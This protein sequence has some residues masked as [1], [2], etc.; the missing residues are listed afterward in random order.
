MDMTS[1]MAG[2]TVVGRNPIT[3]DYTIT[4]QNKDTL[5]LTLTQVRD[6]LPPGL[7]YS[8]ESTSGSLTD[9]DPS[10]TAF[11][12]RQRLDWV[13]DPPIIILS[14][15]TNTIALQVQ[16]PFAGG[17][18]NEVWLTFDEFNNTRY[19]WPSAGITV[20][21]DPIETET[22]IGDTTVYSLLWQIGP[23]SWVLWEWEITN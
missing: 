12:G 1:D 11:Q 19:S 21:S 14:D 6:L 10:S 8:P 3:V 4:F 15:T 18:W 13:F 5:P 22:T 16:G 23:E 7:V 20:I 17:H 2:G 9:S